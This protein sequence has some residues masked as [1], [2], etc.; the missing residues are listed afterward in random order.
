[1]THRSSPH[2][3]A[4]LLWPHTHCLCGGWKYHKRKQSL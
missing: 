4:W 1:M 3:R 2:E